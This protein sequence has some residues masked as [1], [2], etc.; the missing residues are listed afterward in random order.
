MWKYLK[1]LILEL[2]HLTIK[3][4]G[5]YLWFI[6]RDYSLAPCFQAKQSTSDQKKHYGQ[7]C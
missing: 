6:Q 5:G 7:D 1:M 2:I 4:K 3:K